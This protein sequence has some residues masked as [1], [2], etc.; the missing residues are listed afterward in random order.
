MQD[1]PVKHPQ[2][3]I[4][5]A[6]GPRESI[7]GFTA[8]L[9]L[10][11]VLLP[12][13]VVFTPSLYFD[14]DPR[15]L[16]VL[17]QI[18]FG[19]TG[20][21]W[22]AVVSVLIATIALA[23]TAWAGGRIR[24][25]SCGL[26]AA[27]VI[28]CLMHMPE[29]FNSRLHGSAW[30]AAVSLGLA[31]AHLGQFKRAR[32]LIVTALIAMALPLVIHAVWYV[33]IE[34]PA[35]VQSFMQAEG[36]GLSARGMAL[37]S[38]EHAKYLTRLK[39]LD[40]IGAVGMSNVLGS[41]AAAITS[42]GLVIVI[43]G[44]W[45]KVHGA[46]LMSLATVVFMGGLVLALTQSKGAMLA[47]PA[48]FMFGLCVLLL[49]QLKPK[50]HR[51]LPAMCLLLVC[52]GIAAVLVRGAAGPP[53]SSAG[54]RSLLF[55]FHYWQGAAKLLMEDPTRALIGMGQ[56]TFQDYYEAVRNPISPEV[57]T[58]THSVFVDYCVM[59][60]VGGLAWCGL[61]L[62]WLW[63]AGA[64]MGGRLTD[65]AS[66]DRGPPDS[67]PVKLFGLL[68]AIVFGIQL[69]VQY[70]G[71]YAPTAILWLIGSLGF[72][73]L[74]SWVIHPALPDGSAWW[75]L[76]LG[77]TAALVLLHAQIEMTFFWDSAARVM[78]VIVG[79]ASVKS[80]RDGQAHA[81]KP[82]LVRY[83]P[84]LCLLMLGAV[85]ALTFAEP[86]Q[87]HQEQLQRASS[88]L[89]VAGP[90]AAL[91]ELDQAAIIIANDPVTTR[92]RVQLREEIA[93]ALIANG[94]PNDAEAELNEALA[95]L[96]QAQRAGLGRLSSLRRKGSL[97]LDAYAITGERD[98]LRR[99]A[100]PLT[101]AVRLSPHGLN[102]HVRLAD[103]LWQLGEFDP[104]DQTYRRA[105]DISDNYYLDPDTQLPGGQRKRIK[106]RLAGSDD[107]E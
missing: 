52:V 94:R 64:V 6:R 33:F 39:G 12:L 58:S 7:I 38:V 15:G 88:T 10:I 105:L 81:I 73:A 5:D 27:G 35:T 37:D 18:E 76:A 21:L 44:W 42:L 30:I 102:D 56:G 19:P 62:M 60:G 29:H 9:I 97:L 36:D 103:T 24:W 16:A 87:R 14:V 61:L 57:V 95:V 68:A 8:I 70:P 107:S 51:I 49:L 82:S 55:R 80:L 98:W 22:L 54:E 47:F 45:E 91:R 28:P 90:P 77:L 78:W 72:V 104:A 17:D 43:G 101:S 63:G 4:C 100:E 93:A 25:W 92:W 75:S 83:L 48:T 13:V 84:A 3:S 66:R 65:L 86:V 2:D 50:W 59:L 69:A 26:A 85:L 1:R 41:I 67:P 74:A 71:L 32:Q 20:S 99:A 11:P 34:H 79:L 31:A 106:A 89:R 96:D 23:V 46:R 40:V 53:E